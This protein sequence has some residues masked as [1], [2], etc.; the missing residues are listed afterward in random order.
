MYNGPIA[1]PDWFVI[2]LKMVTYVRNPDL[3]TEIIAVTKFL[4]IYTEDY[5]CKCHT[6][7]QNRSFSEHSVGFVSGAIIYF[8]YRYEI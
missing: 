2:Y 8:L 4:I 7:I 6:V 1:Q 5:V 3:K